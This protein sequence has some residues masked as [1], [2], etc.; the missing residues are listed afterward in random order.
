[1]FGL[2]VEI[3]MSSYGERSRIVIPDQQACISTLEAILAILVRT[4][5]SK[6]ILET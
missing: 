4:L 2:K 1:M 3:S 5:P 6:F